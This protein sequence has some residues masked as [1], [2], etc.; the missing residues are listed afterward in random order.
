MKTIVKY[1]TWMAIIIVLLSCSVSNDDDKSS[2]YL[3]MADTLEQSLFEN[4]VNKW[5]PRVIDN[6]HG[7][8][9]TN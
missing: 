2:G 1:P 4:I 5:Y 8:Y 9:L 7:G 3:S 6:Q